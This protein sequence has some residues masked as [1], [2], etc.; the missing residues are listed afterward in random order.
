MFPAF[1]WHLQIII[2]SQ[3]CLTL[4]G[5]HFELAPSLLSL[6]VLRTEEMSREMGVL[7]ASAPSVSSNIYLDILTVKNQYN[8]KWEAAKIG[9]KISDTCTLDVIFS[10]AI[11]WNTQTNLSVL[12]SALLVNKLIWSSLPITL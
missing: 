11:Y 9:Q 12:V 4:W 5:L 7:L 2:I 8:E 6:A 10:F 3:K 1:F